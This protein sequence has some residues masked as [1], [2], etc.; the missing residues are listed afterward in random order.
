MRARISGL[1]LFSLF[2]IAEEPPR[3]QY[4]ATAHQA[5]PVGYRDPL[6]V[7][8]PDGQWLATAVNR[9][10]YI[11]RLNGGPRLELP[12]S[13][14]LK[15][16]IAWLP[17]SAQLA[18]QE[19]KSPGVTE[20]FIVDI[21]S[22]RRRA[23][24]KP[25]APVNRMSQLAWSP[26][27]K[28]IA[29]I[30]SGSELWVAGI[31]GVDPRVTKNG[32][33]LSFP[34]WLPDGQQAAC[35][36]GAEGRFRVV[37][38][39]GETNAPPLSDRDAYGPFAFTPD[40]K[41][42]YFGAL[43]DR[44]TLD[45]W[46]RNLPDG[47]SRQLTNFARDTY[48]PAM[49]RDGR[50]LFKTQI[51]S[52]QIAAVP[53]KGGPVSVLTDFQSETPTWDPTG[54]QIGMTFGTW[55]R[56]ADDARYPDIAQ[57]LGIISFDEPAPA[58]AP[59]TFYASYS[60]DQGMHWSP[61]GKWVVFHSHQQSTDD[62]WLQPA[63]RS[64]TP[65]RI[66]NGGYET[67]WPRWSPDGKWIAYDSYPNPRS[68]L[69]LFY[70]IGV[71]QTTGTTTAPEHVMIRE[72]KEDVSAPQ[73]LPDSESLIFEG[74][75][76]TLGRKSLYRISRRGGQAQRIITYSSDQTVSGIAVSPD[77]KSVAYIAQT[78]GGVFQIF[79]VAATGGASVQ[80]TSDS[81]NKTHPAY[82]PDGQR[83]AFTIWTYDAQF[84]ILQP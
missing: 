76:E 37:A 5:G 73:W 70:V 35:L 33:R 65:R 30:V 80:L 50:V 17:D 20:S 75:G 69:S 56:V 40:G 8:S 11:Q 78:A 45:L 48:A 79:R 52:A 22:G 38:P 23:L 67:G 13:D 62:L 18:V 21:P 27:G 49:M 19:Q 28:R 57:D 24:W 84:W 34:A 10:L 4:V 66:T 77:G 71:D 81:T 51:F 29:G 36:S 31:D 15:P 47:A 61:N 64:T 58:K 42:L 59:Q 6:G 72:F 46:S 63:D 82:S 14:R 7:V 25:D 12:P 68:P 43:N 54:R 2:V 44:G 53:A 3:L 32:T 41:T 74:S 60:E 9:H 1:L 16:W 26:D 55:R 83:L 39:C